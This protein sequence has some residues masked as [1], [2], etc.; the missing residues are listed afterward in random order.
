MSTPVLCLVLF[1]AWA[2]VL[3]LAVGCVRVGRVLARKQ[4]ANS[5]ASGVPHGGDRYWRMNRAHMN[6]VENLPVFGALVLAAEASHLHS[7]A[8]S[9]AAV[10]IVCARA[11][12]SLIHISSNANMA[13]NLRF[14]AFLTQLGGYVFFAVQLL[15]H[16]KVP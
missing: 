4:A 8:L 9:I 7:H 13:V 5:F 11:A 12:Q 14:T 10:V 2:I 15:R 16:Y 3:V 1:A 6:T